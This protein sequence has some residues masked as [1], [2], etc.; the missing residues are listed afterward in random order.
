MKNSELDMV[1]AQEN[2]KPRHGRQSSTTKTRIELDGNTWLQNSISIW[3][4]IRKT[5]EEVALNHPAI[6]PIALAERLITVYSHKS[7]TVLDPFTG[8]STTGVASVR[9]GRRLRILVLA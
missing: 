4:D 2:K 8:S 5:K 7:D 1:K 3:S 6:F 9:N